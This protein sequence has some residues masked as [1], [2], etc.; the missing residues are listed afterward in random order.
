MDQNPTQAAYSD[1]IDRIEILEED[2]AILKRNAHRLGKKIIALREDAALLNPIPPA[3]D[4]LLDADA[5]ITK[6][7]KMTHEQ[8]KVIMD[9]ITDV[10]KEHQDYAPLDIVLDKAEEQGIER[11]RAE[12]IVARLRRDG[13]IIE[14][15][16][17][18]LRP[19]LNEP[20]LSI[21]LPSS[22]DKK[23]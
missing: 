23:P 10:S 19:I 20:D 2:L 11:T 13:S 8:T 6:V 18:M 15:K 17:K 1:I 21:P 9:I 14:P 3:P 4:D 16:H 7:N 5:I 22:Q 12:E